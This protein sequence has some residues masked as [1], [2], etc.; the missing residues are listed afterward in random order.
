M[1]LNDLQIG[2][3]VQGIELPSATLSGSP[4]TSQAPSASVIIIGMRGSGKTH[5]GTVAANF[6]S[7]TFLD[8]DAV[9]E[10]HYQTSVR[11][12]VHDKGWPAFRSAETSLLRKLIAE[13]PTGHVISLGGGIVETEEAREVLKKYGRE[14]GGIVVEIVRE[15]DEVVKYLSAETERPAYGEEIA[16]VYKRREPWFGECSTHQFINYTGLLQHRSNQSLDQNKVE[17]ASPTGEQYLAEVA[18]FFRHVSGQ[19]INAARNVEKYKR[20]YFLSLTYPDI[21]PAL[22]HIDELTIGADAIE[23]RVD[24]LRS[25]KDTETRGL[26]IPPTPYVV[27][28]L[29]ALRQKSSLPIVFTVRTVSQGGSFP[30]GAEDEAFALFDVA[31][32]MGCEYIDI[33]LVWNEAR[34]KEFAKRKG[35]AQIIASWHDWSGNMKWDSDEVKSLYTRAADLGSIVKLVGKATSFSD[36]LTLRS[37]VSSVES[38]KDAKPLIAINTGYEGQLSR[39]LNSTLTPITSPLLPHAAAPGQLSFPQIQSSLHTIGLLP[40]LSFYIFGSPISA[41]PSP[42]LHNAG[43]AKLGL[44]H[45]YE[46][47]ETPTVDESLKKLVRGETF[48]GASVTIPHKLA[49]IPLLDELT[50]HAQ[51]IGAVNTIIPIR[52]SSSSLS[53]PQKLVGDNTDWIGIRN[54]IIARLPPSLAGANAPS[55]ALVIGAGGTARAALYALHH[56]KIPRIYLYNRTLSSAEA[57]RDAFPG[58]GIEVITSLDSLAP[59]GASPTVVVSTVPG[60][61]TTLGS[62]STASAGLLLTKTIFSA[63]QGVVVDMAYKPSETPLLRLAKDVA[64]GRWAVARGLDV[65]LEQGCAQFE[66]WTGKK[67]PRGIVSEKV[68]EYYGDGQ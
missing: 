67:C 35:H 34:I 65:L 59:D 56:L 13:H 11:S 46:R 27:E 21:T 60:S 52:P 22:P 25:P 3:Q 19:T 23:L 42:T 31:A 68:L 62:S 2:L 55:A 9:F 20:S 39:I 18:R 32:R 24:L 48:G 66:L 51:A 16:D 41:S 63:S 49:V 40:S 43:F 10:T 33:E 36:N 61:A 26:Y 45:K 8:A 54:C 44:P 53:A 38:S 58:Y 5:I 30:D 15:V 64:S 50:S 57:L 1:C 14:Q 6:L 37:F 12:Y 28:Q 17:S 29:A 47:S 4:S 7:Y